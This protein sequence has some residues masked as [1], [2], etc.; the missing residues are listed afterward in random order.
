MTQIRGPMDA[1]EREIP[2]LMLPE[3]PEPVRQAYFADPYLTRFGGDYYAY[4]TAQPGGPIA[5]FEAIR[6]SDLVHWESAGQ[7]LEPLDTAFG[8]S[9]WAPEVVER[10][11]RYW[12][13]YS[14][15][16]GI[17]RH[18]IRVAVGDSP[19]GPFADCAVDLTPDESFAID[20]HPFCDVDGRWYLFF[21]RDVLNGPRPGTHLAVTRL[22]SPTQTGAKARAVL[23]PDA[24]WQIYQRGRHMY[25]HTLD[26][27]T[28]EGPTVVRHESVYYLFFSAGSWEGEGY[29]VAVATS[30]HPLGPW[31]HHLEESPGFLSSEVTGLAGPGHNSL[32]S[33]DGSYLTAFHAWN[34]E[35]TARQMYVASVAFL[36]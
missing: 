27:H 34:Q 7:V 25:G 17:E 10:D 26:W 33:V 13:Y 30:A 24:D 9:Y 20:A 16:R 2:R 11:G 12:M 35:R 29:G 8:D 4:G 36:G 1:G 18:H 19:W 3:H 14:V 31:T 5:T 32:L 15:G 23:A 22:A 6:S 28:L 21:A